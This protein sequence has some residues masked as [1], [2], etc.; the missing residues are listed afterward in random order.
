MLNWARRQDSIPLNQTSAPPP[1]FPTFLRSLRRA[2][3][4]TRALVRS[5][6][7]P[8]S[9][10]T[11]ASSFYG[12]PP[13]TWLRDRLAL[14]PTLRALAVPSCS[15]VDHAALSA[16]RQPS[17]QPPDA[18]APTASIYPA[19]RYLDVAGCTN[20]TPAALA[21]ALGCLPGLV[22]LDLS[23]VRTGEAAVGAIR[24]LAGLRVLKMRSCGLG[25]GGLAN[26]AHAVGRRVRSLDVSGN[27][28]TGAGSFA[29][30]YEECMG[31]AEGASDAS[32]TCRGESGDAERFRATDGHIDKTYRRALLEGLNRGDFDFDDSHETGLQELSAAD[33]PLVPSAVLLLFEKRQLAALDL[34]H[35]RNG[36]VVGNLKNRLG[37]KKFDHLLY[38]RVHYS[39][40]TCPS[41]RAENSPRH[42]PVA[43]LPRLR[44]LAL[45]DV[46][47]STAD[48]RVAA[49]II[50]LIEEAAAAAA[51]AR[52]LA[53]GAYELPP[54]RSRGVAER[55]F[56]QS[57]FA[58]RRVVLEMATASPPKLGHDRGRM[59]PQ[60]AKEKTTAAA[61]KSPTRTGGRTSGWRSINSQAKSSTE[62]PDSEAL[63]AAAENDFSFFNGDGNEEEHDINTG[64]ND[65]AGDRA[66]LGPCFGDGCDDL[67]T[68][69]ADIR[70]AST[71]VV[72]SRLPNLYSR[73]GAEIA[74]RG[75]IQERGSPAYDVLAR[76]SSFRKERRAAFSAAASRFGGE[77]PIIEG[78]WEGDVTVVRR[79]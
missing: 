20:A 74:E 78:H 41:V 1:S 72:V 31:N 36:E 30:L 13:P 53:R 77:E 61:T 22:Y 29:V 6:R 26:L 65:D 8:A 71:V 12:S 62:D 11:V 28:V 5:L 39:V 68:R 37:E 76:L 56:A 35:V 2:R 52:Q 15:H 9:L 48:Q 25:D 51:H 57:A 40:V 45:T 50:A 38:L 67:R 43:L 42:F 3:P 24:E 49:E 60:A 63:W 70:E 73:D 21:T 54:N 46:P 16:L 75:G 32:G 4:A 18:M 47:L 69:E 27:G 64:S 7:L 10:P 59:E 55:E 44:T 34:G 66:D 17:A 23:R 58:L 19:L 33:N 14:I 79:S